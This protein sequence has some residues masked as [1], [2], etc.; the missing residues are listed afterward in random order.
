MYLSRTQFYMVILHSG[1][2]LCCTLKVGVLFALYCIVPGFSSG[3]ICACV[4][5][6]VYVN[7]R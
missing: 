6:H 4:Y 7:E 5:I 1:Y 3:K 2:V